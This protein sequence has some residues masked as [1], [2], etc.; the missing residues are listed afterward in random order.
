M[1]K[2]AYN[3]SKRNSLDKEEILMKDTSQIFQEL[4]NEVR[5]EE[6]KFLKSINYSIDRNDWYW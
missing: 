1:E 5:E 4:V 6:L 2:G 3:D